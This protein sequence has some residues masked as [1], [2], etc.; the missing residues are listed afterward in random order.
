MKKETRVKD[1][2]VDLIKLLIN[3]LNFNEPFRDVLECDAMPFLKIIDW[4]KATD[5]ERLAYC[6]VVYKDKEVICLVD[7]HKYSGLKFRTQYSNNQVWCDGAIDGDGGWSVC[8]YKDGKFAEIIEEVE[9]I[10]EAPAK[11]QDQFVKANPDMSHSVEFKEGEMVDVYLEGTWCE[12]KYAFF[13]SGEHWYYNLSIEDTVHI[14]DDIRK[15]DPD[16]EIK[17]YAKEIMKRYIER[18]DKR[19]ELMLIE[20]M[21]KVQSKK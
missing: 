20:A 19:M 13:V 7:G 14:A 1:L 5:A 17:Q 6:E 9:T 3:E 2:K 15:I 21:K 18:D 16:K 8:L 12:R 10:K 11:H 4:T